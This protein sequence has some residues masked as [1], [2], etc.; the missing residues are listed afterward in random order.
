M[1]SARKGHIVTV[2]SIASY[3][4]M[5]PIIHY[6]ATKT[7]AN[8]ISDGLRSELL[9]LYPNG[10]TILTTSVHPTFHD[11]P[12]TRNLVGNAKTARNKSDVIYPAENVSKKVVQQ[13]LQAKSGKLFMPEGQYWVSFMKFAPIWL[14][15]LIV[16]LRASKK[17][18]EMARA[19]AE[20]S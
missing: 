13:V 9:T 17:R 1:L 7:A 14:M 3:L 18:K 15:D 12:M 4:S 2:A 10:N 6:C 11:T 20:A 5:P 16:F 8:Y 19:A